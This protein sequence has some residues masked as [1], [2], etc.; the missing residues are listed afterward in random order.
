M[1]K[2]LTEYWREG[3]CARD[4]QL[5]DGDLEGAQLQSLQADGLQ[6]RDCNLRGADFSRARWRH[7]ALADIDATLS[8]WRGAALR[9]CSFESV[10]F[11]KADFTGAALENSTASGCSFRGASFTGASL[12]DSDLSRCDLR[13]TVFTDVDANGACLRG[14]DLRGAQLAGADFSYADLRGADFSGTDTSGADFTGADLRGALLESNTDEPGETKSEAAADLPPGFGELAQSVGPL[15]AELLRAG[16][17]SGALEREL[18][19][20]LQ[21]Q[22][23]P[24]EDNPQLRGAVAAML[25][26]AGDTG[27]APLINALGEESPPREVAQMLEKLRGDFGLGEDATAEDLLV[28]L[29]ASLQGSSRV[30]E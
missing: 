3:T 5:Q 30:P 23:G 29:C 14:A 18:A 2:E 20:Q 21:A 11:S 26:C 19:D 1:L 17:D 12:V 13:E 28:S 7:C 22:L 6:I 4:L 8:R 15:L 9:L 10:N 25:H 16:R 27:V 24:V